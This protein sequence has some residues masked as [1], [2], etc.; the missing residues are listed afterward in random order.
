MN[1][2]FHLTITDN[3]TGEVLQ[4]LDFDALLGAVHIEEDLSAT[5]KV[6]DCDAIALA[7]TTS[8]LRSVLIKIYKDYPEILFMETYIHTQGVDDTEENNN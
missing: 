2:P 3:M 4:D 5:L 8:S 6:T 1:K 7:K